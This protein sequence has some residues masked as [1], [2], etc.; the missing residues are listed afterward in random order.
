MRKDIF[1]KLFWLLLTF[2]I[3]T[4]LD[5]VKYQNNRKISCAKFHA[6]KFTALNPTI[7]KLWILLLELKTYS[8][9]RDIRRCVSESKLAVC[10]IPPTTNS[11]NLSGNF[12]LLQLFFRWFSY[13]LESLYSIKMWKYFVSIS[14]WAL[15]KLFLILNV[16]IFCSFDSNQKRGRY[17]IQLLAGGLGG[18]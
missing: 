8:D 14:G 18:L 12:F 5:L 7:L 4:V 15:E 17:S 9:S 6:M 16:H 13:K 10:D 11:E 1:I 3:L 2:K